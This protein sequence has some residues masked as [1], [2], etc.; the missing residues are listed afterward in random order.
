M[1]VQQG[2]NSHIRLLLCARLHGQLMQCARGH[3][4]H[5]H[6]SVASGGNSESMSARVGLSERRHLCANQANQR[7]AQLRLCLSAQ[8]HRTQV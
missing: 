1:L 5:N 7:G 2:P 4:A 8:L 3:T 6:C